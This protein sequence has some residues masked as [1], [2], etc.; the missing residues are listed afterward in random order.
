MKELKAM[1]YKFQEGKEYSTKELMNRIEEFIGE[2]PRKVAYT[3][4]GGNAFSPYK[5]SGAAYVIV[6]DGKII[7]SASKGSLHST[8]NR[9]E[10][11]A[12]V[13][14]ML[15]VEDGER[16]V[17]ITD[18][19]FSI[20]VLMNQWNYANDLQD[21]FFDSIGEREIIFCHVNSHKGLYYNEYVDKMATREMDK[22]RKQ[23]NIPNYTYQNSPL[24]AEKRAMAAASKIS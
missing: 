20:N 14:A 1:R 23:Y 7:K 13:S 5:E 11:L 8:N 3:D 10:M 16:L 24:Y 21:I 18:S 2:R 12:I 15:S 19:Q 17:I 9:M 6:E 4:G 22:L